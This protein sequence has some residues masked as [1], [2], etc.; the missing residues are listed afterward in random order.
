M[1]Q[2]GYLVRGVPTAFS[3]GVP[4]SLAREPDLKAGS[5][6]PRVR[7]SIQAAS[8]LLDEDTGD[9]HAQSSAVGGNIEPGRQTCALIA[10][11]DVTICILTSAS[12][13]DFAAT[14]LRRVG[15]KLVYDQPDWLN[16]GSG[17]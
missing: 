10:H 1:Y 8:K 12:D 2:G 4:T 11:G 15:N 9:F 3:Q 16:M 14:V 7:L 5:L 13:I 6:A 17:Q